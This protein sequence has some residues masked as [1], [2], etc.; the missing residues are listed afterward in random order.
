[1]DAQRTGWKAG[2]GINCDL[3]KNDSL[4]QR[5]RE[6]RYDEKRNEFLK[7]LGLKAVHIL[8]ADVKKNIESAIEYIRGLV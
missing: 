5:A 2:K 3:P 8:D 7:D 1:M 4:K 6:L